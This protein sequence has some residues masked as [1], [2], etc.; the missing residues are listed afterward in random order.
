V[1]AISCQPLK[2]TLFC[3]GVRHMGHSC[4]SCLHSASLHLLHSTVCLQGSSCTAGGASQHTW[5][6][7]GNEHHQ[8][9]DRVLVPA[10]LVLQANTMPQAAAAASQPHHVTARLS[11]SLPRELTLWTHMTQFRKAGDVNMACVKYR[12]HHMM[13]A[14]AR[15]AVNSCQVKRGCTQHAAISMLTS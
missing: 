11:P 10:C 7:G 12:T 2:L 8:H 6:V 14:T 15:Y 4:P 9:M 13:A 1:P 3:T 5:W